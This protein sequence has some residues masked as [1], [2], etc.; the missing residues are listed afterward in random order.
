MLSTHDAISAPIMALGHVDASPGLEPPK[1]YVQLPIDSILVLI[2]TAK[3]RWPK[4]GP[5]RI[6]ATFR[7]DGGTEWKLQGRSWK[8]PDVGDKARIGATFEE[9]ERRVVVDKDE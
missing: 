9:L 8:V 7:E 4:F 1:N 2:E 5:W 3:R 6:S